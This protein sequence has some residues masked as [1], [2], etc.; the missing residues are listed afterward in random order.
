MTKFQ[1]LSIEVFSW[2][3]VLGYCC[4]HSAASDQQE[5]DRITFRRE[6]CFELTLDNRDLIWFGDPASPTA[7]VYV[8]PGVRPIATDFYVRTVQEDP[9]S[10]ARRY[11]S[12]ARIASDNDARKVYAFT[13]QRERLIGVIDGRGHFSPNDTYKNRDLL[14]TW[15]IDPSVLAYDGQRNAL[16]YEVEVPGPLVSES[17]DFLP[18]DLVD[19]EGNKFGGRFSIDYA[20]VEGDREAKKLSQVSLSLHG[21]RTSRVLAIATVPRVFRRADVDICSFDNKSGTYLPEAA[22][23]TGAT[24]KSD[25]QPSVTVRLT[26][27]LT[28]AIQSQGASLI[29]AEGSKERGNPDASAANIKIDG[30]FNDWRNIAGVDDPRGDLVPYLDYVPDVDILEFKVA[31]DDEHIYYYVRVAGQVGKSHP[32]G[33]RSYFY[34]YMDVD[35]NPG[36]GFLPSRDD[37]CY[38]GVDIGDDCE[39]QFEF[40]NNAFRKTFYGFC[41]LGGDEKVLQ[42]QLTLGKSVYGRFDANGAQRANYKSEYTYRDRVTEIT[43]DLKRGTSDTIRL[44]ISPDGHEVE[45]AST[46]TGFLKDSKGR[47]TVKLGQTIDVAAGMECDSKA[48]LGKTNWAADNTI[49]IRGY[50]LSPSNQRAASNR[51][52]DE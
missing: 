18:L 4:A 6:A 40:V 50:K 33:G 42:Q 26:G 1:L 36:T 16:Y 51:A 15:P 14:P 35:Q 41:G 25:A 5:N 22:Y 28:S 21:K 44:A 27:E 45:V 12:E 3:L 20:P 13:K 2:G 49:A 37:E 32:D 11:M 34:A 47:P 46:F 30:N 29:V 39:V 38:Y 31:H 8:K 19:A 43:E 24:F 7:L 9:K 10:P 52:G 17:L 48:Y 23:R